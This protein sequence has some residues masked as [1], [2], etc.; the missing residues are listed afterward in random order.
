VL[1][2]IG[3]WRGTMGGRTAALVGDVL[4]IIGTLYTLVVIVAGIA[5]LVITRKP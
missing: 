3:A 1:R 5:Y 4:G 2:E